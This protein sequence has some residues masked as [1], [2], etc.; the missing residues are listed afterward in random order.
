MFIIGHHISKKPLLRRP[1]NGWSNRPIIIMRLLIF[2]CGI[3]KYRY[4]V[5]RTMEIEFEFSINQLEI[6]YNGAY[7]SA[8][9]RQDYESQC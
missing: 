6:A 3:H 1:L 7:V 5:N 8:S 9:L 2:L 4:T